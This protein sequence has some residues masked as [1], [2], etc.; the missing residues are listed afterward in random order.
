MIVTSVGSQTA[1]NYWQI[2]SL[3]LTFLL[4]RG[5]LFLNK[6]LHEHVG[7]QK[8]IVISMYMFMLLLAANFR[9][10]VNVQSSA[11]W[12]GHSWCSA[13]V[14]VTVCWEVMEWPEYWVLS[15]MKLLLSLKRVRSGSFS[16]VSTRSG[17][18]EKASLRASSQSCLGG[19]RGLGGS[20]RGWGYSE[21][22]T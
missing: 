16:D 2:S 8:H 11:H 19:P 12:A 9:A 13:L 17:H 21:S 15:F 3:F 4:L 18:P 14:S 20:W 22:G 1:P 10:W 7:W 6:M 5:V